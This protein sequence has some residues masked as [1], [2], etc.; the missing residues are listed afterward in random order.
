MRRERD[1]PSTVL[2]DRQVFGIDVSN[3][4][5]DWIES[6]DF[7]A[8]YAGFDDTGSRREYTW[9]GFT[10]HRARVNHVGSVNQAPFEVTWDTRML[11]D[12]GR[13]LAVRAVL[14]LKG[15]LLYRTQVLDNL[16]LPADRPHVKLYR[17][18][19]P[20]RP[21][22]SRASRE[23]NATIS[24]PDDLSNVA[25]AE[26]WVK[27]WDGG[28]GKE[29]EPFRINGHAYDIISGKAIHNVVFTRSAVDVMH[30]KPGVNKLTLIS[31]THHHGI[32]IL[33]PGPVLILQ[34]K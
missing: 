24:L 8:R 26:L 14:H 15:G 5:E 23:K 2:Q 21:F 6:V 25:A 30:L 20:P 3:D 28:A 27:T 18:D 33:A 10:L 7:F 4:F 13:P 1:G 19:N 9:H 34:F 11:P 22:W 32:E 31:E 16:R 29:N 17:C 12:Q